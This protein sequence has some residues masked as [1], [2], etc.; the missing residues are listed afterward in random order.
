MTR[1]SFLILSYAAPATLAW[2]VVGVVANAIPA[3]RYAP[4]VMACYALYYGVVE[5]GI[6]AG[7]RPPGTGWQVPQ[8]FV[9]GVPARTRILVWGAFLGPGFATRNPYGGFFLLPI[10]LAAIG[11]VPAGA[12][13]AAA[14]GFAHGSGRALSLLRDARHIA[15]SDYLQNVLKSIYWRV[16]DGYALLIICGAALIVF[17]SGR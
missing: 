10:A 7:I 11:N 16:F 8:S 3:S 13:V 17:A 15:V 6:L 5:T 9:S 12:A 2:A 4:I 1:Y 14:I